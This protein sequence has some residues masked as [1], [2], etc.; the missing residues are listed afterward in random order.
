[1]RPHGG[2]DFTCGETTK[3]LWDQQMARGL[4]GET[5]SMVV[6]PFVGDQPTW[7]MGRR[8]ESGII[9]HAGG[10]RETLMVAEPGE[11]GFSDERC[12]NVRL[13]AGYATLDCWGGWAST[14]HRAARERCYRFCS[15]VKCRG[16]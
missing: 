9:A 15:M 14:C 4:C 10:H 5:A 11:M 13:G 7:F 2:E 6:I 3:D 12:S 1:M 16:G 8:R